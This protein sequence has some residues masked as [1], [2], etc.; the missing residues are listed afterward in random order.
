MFRGLV[1]LKHVDNVGFLV[2]KLAFSSSDNQSI[3]SVC[4]HKLQA[5]SQKIYQESELVSILK[6]ILNISPERKYNKGEVINIIERINDS[7]STQ[8]K[9]K[10]REQE[11]YISQLQNLFLGRLLV[12]YAFLN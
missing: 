4:L 12:T 7:S 5:S 2:M 6:Q 3:K 8:V 1:N 11:Q 9:D 10:L